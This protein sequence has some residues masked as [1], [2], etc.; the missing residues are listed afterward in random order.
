MRSRA[1]ALVGGSDSAPIPAGRWAAEYLIAERQADI[2]L[3]YASY[4]DVLATCPQVKVRSLPAALDFKV[5]YGLC[6]LEAGSVAAQQLIT[7]ILGVQ[8]QQILQRM[9]MLPLN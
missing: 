9:G 3:G 1:V 2:F 7:F 5:T 4:A 8:G 6:L